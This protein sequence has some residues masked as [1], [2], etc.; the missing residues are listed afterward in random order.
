MGFDR[1]TCRGSP[2]GRKEDGLGT[3]GSGKRPTDAE[4]AR[5]RVKA[6][7]VFGKAG[8][9]LRIENRTAPAFE[10]IGM[11]GLYFFTSEQS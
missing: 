8:S 3:K 1:K 4:S 11:Q 5:Y 9:V 10:G 2:E 6:E 7:T